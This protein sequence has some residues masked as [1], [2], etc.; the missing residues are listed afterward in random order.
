MT[1]VT[2]YIGNELELF[3]HAHNWKNYWGSKVKP[4]LGERV[5]E[6]GAGLGGTTQHLFNEKT[7]KQWT[8]LEPD[9]AL[10]QGIQD[11]IDKG[12]IPNKCE[13]IVKTLEQIAQSL[14]NKNLETPNSGAN[15]T[16]EIQNL[17]FT[18]GGYDAIIYIDVIEHIE[19]DKAELAQTLP[20]LKKDGHLIILVPAHQF[21][22]SPFDKA[23]GHFRRYN[24]PHLKSVIPEGYEIVKAQYLD[25]VGLAASLANKLFLK[26][27]YPTLKQILF[28]DKYIVSTSKLVDKMTFHNFGKSVLLIARNTDY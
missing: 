10:A 5:L 12:L 3:S 28:W 18:E 13:I 1:D 24:R 16:S 15:L 9:P 2:T 7:I 11:K 6:V 8:C 4:Y 17:K 19:N 25:T 22:F 21:L 14:K 27:S 26:Q 20:F 23:I